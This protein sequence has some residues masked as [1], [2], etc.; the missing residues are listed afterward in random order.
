MLGYFVELAAN[1][2]EVIAVAAAEIILAKQIIMRM[3]Q[4]MC[5]SAQRAENLVAMMKLISA[6]TIVHVNLFKTFNEPHK[7]P[8]KRNLP[9]CPSRRPKL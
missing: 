9:P 4:D 5:D 8:C 2:H 1:G 7:G 6:S 3:L